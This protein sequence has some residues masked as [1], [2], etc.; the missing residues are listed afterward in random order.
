MKSVVEV[1]WKNGIMYFFN[2]IN[3]VQTLL[4]Y[5]T[6]HTQTVGVEDHVRPI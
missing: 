5:I 4:S 3:I 2:S 6:I 1:G